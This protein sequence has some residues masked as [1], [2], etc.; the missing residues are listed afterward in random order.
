MTVDRSAQLE[1]LTAAH[2]DVF[3]GL[4]A[5]TS[6][7]DPS[8]WSTP[9]GC[10]GWD[11]HD[12]LAH[13][14]G[15]ERRLLGDPDRD[16]DVVVPDLDHLTGE[17][18]RV[19][20]RDVEARRRMPPETL[21]AEAADAFGR[22]LAVLSE[23]APDALDREVDGLFGRQRLAGFLRTR[24]FDLACH[25]RDVR[26]ALGRLDGFVGPHVD[27][28]T[29]QALRSL[30]RV[31]PVRIEGAGTLHLEVEAAPVAA[32]DLGTGTLNR[33]DDVTTPADATLTLSAA[34]LLAVAGGRSD[35]PALAELS[36]SGDEALLA[37]VLAVAGVT[38]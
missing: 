12:Q 16:P 29:E 32:L 13:C 28:A 25:E 38:P 23:T 31:L 11:V 26:S 1:Q 15:L 37:A 35:A 18:G 10:P 4:L 2:R 3:A 6:D 8:G 34:Q 9:T 20:E 19:I 14:V 24:V 7:L 30:A 17:V 22:R 33:G 27:L 36:S 21:R 5:V